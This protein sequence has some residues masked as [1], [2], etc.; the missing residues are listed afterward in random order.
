MGWPLL[1]K[2]S[3]SIRWTVRL[4]SSSAFRA[5]RGCSRFPQQPVYQF[6]DLSV[7]H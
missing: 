4:C 3:V 2:C 7:I 6:T 1:T 5:D